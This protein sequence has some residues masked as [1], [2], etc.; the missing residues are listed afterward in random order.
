MLMIIE[1]FNHLILENLIHLEMISSTVHTVQSTTSQYQSNPSLIIINPFLR[2]DNC[3]SSNS[4]LYNNR[5]NK[6]KVNNSL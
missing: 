3:S 4:R 2:I 6:W 1:V 5:L